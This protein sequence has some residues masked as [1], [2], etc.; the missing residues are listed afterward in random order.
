MRT[1]IPV[2]LVTLAA[3]GGK[4]HLEEYRFSQRTLGVSFIE[5]PRAELKH[6]WYNVDKG[7][8]ALQTVVQAGAT[9]AKEFEARRALAR[10]DSAER[11]VDLTE[12]LAN[13]TA[14][15]ASRYLGT[16]AATDVDAADYILE[17]HMREF[18]IDASSNSATYLYSRAEAVLID[19][20][21]GREIWS[22]KVKAWDRLTPYI[23]GTMD[24]PSAIFTAATLHTVT[25]AQFQRALEQLVVLT[26]NVI[27]SELREDLRDARD[28]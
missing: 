11:A 8:S 5:P 27:A 17:L 20:R 18:G 12:L 24:A 7:G 26:S 4:H 13:G 3:C 14:Q 6:G 9:V 22:Q 28:R 15:R 25:V 1:L 2:L 19:R 23:V 16:S 10:L 21:S